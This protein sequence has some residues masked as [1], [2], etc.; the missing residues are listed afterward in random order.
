[1]KTADF[2]IFILSQDL[3]FVN[4]CKLVA[5]NDKIV[6]LLLKNLKKSSIIT[7]NI[8]ERMKI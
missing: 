6:N 2:A 7:N 5:K 4:S 3:K 8:I 1:M